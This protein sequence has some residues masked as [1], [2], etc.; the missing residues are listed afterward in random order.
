[1]KK[2]LL[3]SLIVYPGIAIAGFC[4][5]FFIRGNYELSGYIDPLFFA[6]ALVL[7]CG[8]LTVLAYF[9]A[10]DFLAYGF[11]SL[12]K[13]MVPG[14]TNSQDEYPDY[15]AYNEARKDKRKKAGLTF[16]PWLILASGLLIASFVIRAIVF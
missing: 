4:L 3:V 6:G 12:F 15:Y 11:R 10:F 8:M 2:Q 16:W 9:G 13:H 5:F 1:M 14:Y 7:M